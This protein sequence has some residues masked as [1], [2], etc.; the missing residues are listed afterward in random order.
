MTIVVIILSAGDL[1]RGVARRNE[2]APFAEFGGCDWAVTGKVKVERKSRKHWN[3]VA[4]SI[5]DADNCEIWSL[6]SSKFLFGEPTMNDIA[7]QVQY[8]GLC[9]RMRGQGRVDYCTDLIL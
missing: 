6:V 5:K 4:V 8:E 3:A 2:Y 9:V 1:T 7:C